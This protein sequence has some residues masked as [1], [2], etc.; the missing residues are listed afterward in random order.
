MYLPS[1][2]SFVKSIAVSFVT[3]SINVN[4]IYNTVLPIASGMTGASNIDLHVISLSRNNSYLSHL[5][6]QTS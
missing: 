3:S 6:H 1:S 4:N 2:L 5:F